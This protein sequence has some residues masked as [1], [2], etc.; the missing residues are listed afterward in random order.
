MYMYIYKYTINV[1]VHQF[2]CLK[3]LTLT[4]MKTIHRVTLHGQIGNENL[5]CGCDTGHQKCQ[6]NINLVSPSHCVM[7]IN[8][9]NHS[10]T[11]YLTVDS[12]VY[13]IYVSSL[14]KIYLLPKIN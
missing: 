13:F 3:E 7:Q 1:S 5:I 10:P 6:I 8:A 2:S 12:I 14:D 4:S 11:V 9:I